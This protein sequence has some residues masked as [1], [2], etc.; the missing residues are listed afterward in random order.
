MALKDNDIRKWQYTEHARVKHLILTKYLTAWIT[1]L[2]SRERRICYFD[3]FAG[4]GEYQDGTLGSPI[5]AFKA[6]EEVI[7]NTKV[8]DFE[9]NCVF[10]EKDEDNFNNLKMVVQRELA[11]YPFVNKVLYLHDDFDTAI[12][13]LLDEI[14]KENGQIAPSFFFI[15]PFGFTGVNFKTI[16]RILAQKKTEIFFN[17]MVRDVNR[18]LN[19]PNQEHNMNL[20]FGNDSWKKLLNMKGVKRQN[21]L[22]DLY[23]DNLLNSGAAK[24]VWPFRVCE[25]NRSATLYYLIFATNNF[26]GLE[27]MKGIMFNQNEHFA[28][29]GPKEHDYQVSRNQLRLFDFEEEHLKSF[30]LNMY[31]NT[32]KTYEQIKEETYMYNYCI[33][34]HYRNAIKS[35]EKENKVKIV[36][37][38][39]KRSG[40]KGNDIIIFP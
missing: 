23:I 10:I 17:F 37:V 27:V 15:D 29:L 24:Y 31:K 35:L 21:A 1:I 28:Y 18:F 26:K 32:S 16:Q 3:G 13:S 12:N 20:L 40:L 38:S 36:R 9:F 25:D 8:R 11:K 6:L 4:R 34:K 2:G 7:N 39:S 5:I 19:L 30:L 33:D 14:E 22:R